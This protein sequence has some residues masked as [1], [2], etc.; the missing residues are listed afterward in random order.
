M[1]NNEFSFDFGGGDA[2]GSFGDFKF[3][4]AS[5]TFDPAP[6]A[7]GSTGATPAANAAPASESKA[8]E[9]ALDFGLG[10]GLDFGSMGDWGSMTEGALPVSPP[11]A[12]AKPASAAAAAAAAGSASATPANPQQ[13]KPSKL[14]AGAGVFSSALKGLDAQPNSV[15]QRA[16]AKALPDDDLDKEVTKLAHRLEESPV[17]EAE[18]P[19]KNNMGLAQNENESQVIIKGA[20]ELSEEYRTVGGKSWQDLGL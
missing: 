20:V 10:G 18:G 14:R 8:P 15:Q 4:D 3:D 2:A 11:P 6:A 7:T 19:V 9:P 17:I 12:Q 16:S 13:R 5:F 1:A